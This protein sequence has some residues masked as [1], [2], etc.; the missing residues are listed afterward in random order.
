MLKGKCITPEYVNNRPQFQVVSQI[1][2]Q[3][4]LS[5]FLVS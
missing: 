1:L 4:L 3:P 5:L 2:G